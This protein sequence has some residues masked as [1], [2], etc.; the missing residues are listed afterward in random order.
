MHPVNIFVFMHFPTLHPHYLRFTVSPV[1]SCLFLLV[2]FL[3]LRWFVSVLRCQRA[4]CIT[5]GLVV[6]VDPWKVLQHTLQKVWILH[7]VIILLIL[8]QNTQRRRLCNTQ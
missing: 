2:I 5:D 7:H 1:A 4:H 8:L 6:G 3:S